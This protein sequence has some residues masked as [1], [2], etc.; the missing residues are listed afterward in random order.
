M[1]NKREFELNNMKKSIDDNEGI[2][3]KINEERT[4]AVKKTDSR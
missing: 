3:K 4:E 1:K 2:I